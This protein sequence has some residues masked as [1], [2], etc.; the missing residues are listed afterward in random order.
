MFAMIRNL[1]EGL[2]APGIEG[3]GLL[4]GGAPGFTQQLTSLAIGHAQNMGRQFQ[5]GWEDPK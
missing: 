4:G 2:G 5:E 3:A 1:S